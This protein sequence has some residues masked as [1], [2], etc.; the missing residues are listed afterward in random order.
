MDY[1]NFTYIDKRS[2]G[3]SLASLVVA[4]IGLATGCCVYTGIICGALAIMFALL[5]KGGEL[6]MDGKAKAG[7]TIGIISIVFSIF[8]LIVTLALT[9]S[10]F[11]S[12]ENFLYEYNNI[13]KGNQTF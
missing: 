9:I 4:I 10:S 1:Q 3:F 2:N 7:L 11:G 13:L 8:V 12:F 6:T 5:S